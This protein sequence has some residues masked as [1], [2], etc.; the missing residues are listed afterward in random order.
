MKILITG[1]AGF[2]GFHLS[3]SLLKLGH[4]IVGMDNI[5]DYYDISLKKDRLDLL[6]S[7]NNFKFHKIDLCDFEMLQSIVSTFKPDIVINLAAQAGVRYSINNP[8][9]Y[10][11]S[12]LE[13]FLNILEVC[14]Q[15][16]IK[17]LIY[18]SSSSVYGNS[19]KEFFSEEDDVNNPISLYAA[20]KKANELMAHTYSHL[21][22]INC[23]G[24]RFFTV[25]GPF[26]RP[27][28]AY[29]NFLKLLYSNKPI[30]VYG[31]G[32]LYRDFTYIDDI[33]NGIIGSIKL[34]ESEPYNIINLGN[35]KP[36]KLSDYILEIEKITGKV[37]IKNYLDEQPGDVKRTSANID[38]A[39]S[40]LGY[41]PNVD[42]NQG[43][44]TFIKW[45]EEY[46]NIHK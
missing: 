44:T 18:A 9:A 46:Y 24:L 8:F 12:N 14:R 3:N 13:G 22:N 41:K 20:T 5:N 37:F 7:N 40:K 28:M 36:I 10:Q 32:E 21:Y 25:Y 2:I 42:I 26:G 29:F 1:A 33:I 15:N 38:R 45:Y 17:K 27:D 30:D 23:I 43:M 34:V 39:V 16:N 6:I 35:N 11:K 4:E 19:E 31:G